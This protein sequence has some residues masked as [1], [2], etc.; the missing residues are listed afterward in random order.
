MTKKVHLPHRC[1]YRHTWEIIVDL[2][3]GDYPDPLQRFCHDCL[4]EGRIEVGS[5]QVMSTAFVLQRFHLFC[6]QCVHTFMVP[7]IPQYDMAFDPDATLMNVRREEKLYWFQ[8]PLIWPRCSYCEQSLTLK[9][10]EII[11]YAQ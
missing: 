3:D 1:N 8:L 10:K 4:E 2:R 5:V 9:K 7:L 11:S 6:D